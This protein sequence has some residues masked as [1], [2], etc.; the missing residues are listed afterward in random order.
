MIGVWQ[1]VHKKLN[2]SLM[3]DTEETTATMLETDLKDE[4]LE[5]NRT[6][7]ITQL[8]LEQVQYPEVCVVTV[9]CNKIRLRHKLASTSVRR[10][11]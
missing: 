7:A 3:V 4:R 5:E 11:R 10:R 1:P 2:S 6:P 9:E 8:P